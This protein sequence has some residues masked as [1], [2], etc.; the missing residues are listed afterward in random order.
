[1]PLS[2]YTNLG[3]RNL[4]YTRLTVELADRTIKHPK[5]IAENMLVKIGVASFN[6]VS[7]RESKGNNLKKRGSL[8]IKSM[9]TSK[10]FKKPQS[11]RN[12]WEQSASEMTTLQ[13]SYDMEIMF[14]ETSQYVTYTMLRALDTTFSLLDNF[15]M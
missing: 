9:S 11:N 4:A 13:Q 5:G 12:L 1:M 8:H 15:A 2:T 3:L 10:E 7:R 14:R 6:S